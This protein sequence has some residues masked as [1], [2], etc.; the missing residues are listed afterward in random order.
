MKTD[1]FLKQ[2]GIPFSTHEH[3]PAYT[4]QEVAAEEHISGN[5]V[6]KTVV[7]RA[8]EQYALCVLPASFKLDL[9]KVAQ[10]LGVREALL[11]DETEMAKLFPD[12]EVGAESPLGVL[13]D[14]PTVVDERL[15]GH[16]EI[17]FQAETHR[18]AIHM[19]FDD[20]SR[21]TDP[22][23]ADIAVHL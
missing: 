15:A 5:R 20:Y 3:L 23:V 9:E 2:H 17:I 19:K 21:L 10:A 13:Y 6:A 4:A 11:A 22:I 1:Q 14:L 7:V 18:Q 16:D 8:G 12:A